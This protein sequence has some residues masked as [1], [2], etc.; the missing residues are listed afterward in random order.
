MRCISSKI[1]YRRRSTKDVIILILSL[2]IVLVF[3]IAALHHVILAHHD[4]IGE[5]CPI[6]S[7]LLNA[8]EILKLLGKVAQVSYISGLSLFTLL[9]VILYVIIALPI[10]TTLVDINTKLNS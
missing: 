5:G 3:V 9:I 1:K 7:K 10:F 8:T 4:C 2:C 6:C